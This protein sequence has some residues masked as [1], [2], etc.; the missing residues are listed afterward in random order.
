[1]TTEEMKSRNG[2]KV[3]NINKIR[4]KKSAQNV[5]DGKAALDHTFDFLLYVIKSVELLII[6]C[7]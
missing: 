7:K 2:R 4:N 1:M 3:S 5:L 6:I